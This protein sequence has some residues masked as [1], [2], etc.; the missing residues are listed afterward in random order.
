MTPQHKEEIETIVFSADLTHANSYDSQSQHRERF[1]SYEDL[2][3]LSRKLNDMMYCSSSASGGTTNTNTNTTSPPNQSQRSDHATKDE[4]DSSFLEEA[5]EQEDDEYEFYALS[6]FSEYKK[7]GS[8]C[9]EK[10]KQKQ[11]TLC[12]IPLPTATPPKP[13]IRKTDVQRMRQWGK[14]MALPSFLSKPE[15]CRK[16]SNE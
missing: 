11:P 14:R 8:S 5:S 13:V 12:V 7:R 15:L 2:G 9:F 16:P 4:V 10:Q 3:E 6:M 1:F